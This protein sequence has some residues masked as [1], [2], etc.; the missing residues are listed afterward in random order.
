MNVHLASTYLLGVMGR[1]QFSHLKF[2]RSII[3]RIPKHPVCS[4]QLIQPAYQPPNSVFLSQQISHFS[5]STG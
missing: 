4:L 1:G 2:S 3:Y 5:F